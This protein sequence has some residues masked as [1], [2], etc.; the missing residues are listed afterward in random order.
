MQSNSSQQTKQIAAD[1]AK[2]LKGGE[3]IALFGELGA[4]KTTFVQGLSS[5]LGVTD[6]VRSPTFV[7]AHIYPTTHET[8]KHLVHV[9]FYRIQHAADFSDLGL[10]E[11]IN[12]EDTVIVAEWPTGEFLTKLKNPV[13]VSFSIGKGDERGIDISRG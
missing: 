8:I 3:G 12:K 6:P 9:D 11:Y 5:A 2:T 4:G 7:L 1:F 10:D 13:R